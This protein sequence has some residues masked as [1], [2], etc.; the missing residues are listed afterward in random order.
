M[1]ENF[2]SENIKKDEIKMKNKE[3][4]YKNLISR[5]SE[6]SLTISLMEKKYLN[7]L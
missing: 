6:I 5:L 7:K 2:T 4:E 3:C 1:N